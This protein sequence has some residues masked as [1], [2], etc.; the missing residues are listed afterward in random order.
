MAM[1]FEEYEGGTWDDLYRVATV[2]DRE[3]SISLPVNDVNRSVDLIGVEGPGFSLNG[4]VVGK[5]GDALVERLCGHLFE[6]FE[7][8]LVFEEFEIRDR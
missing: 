7:F 1:V 2:F 6:V 4:H 5:P 3:D 8:R